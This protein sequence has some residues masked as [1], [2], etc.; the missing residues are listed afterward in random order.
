MKKQFKILRN[1]LLLILSVIL[2]V[3]LTPF[4]L[5]TTLILPRY[6]QLY[7][8]SKRLAKIALSIDQTGNVIMADLFNIVLISKDGYKFGNEDETISSALGKNKKQNK[9]TKVGKMLDWVL[10]KIEPNHSIKYIEFDE[11]TKQ[12]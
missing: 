5:L 7:T 4:G 3:I 1:L 2:L 10:D 8:I 6:D 11:H 12:K 9:L